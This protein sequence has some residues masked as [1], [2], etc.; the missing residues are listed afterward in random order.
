MTGVSSANGSYLRACP[1]ADLGDGE[2]TRVELDGRTDLP[3]PHRGRGARR[4]A[5]CART[6]TSRSSEGEV[7]GCTIECWLHGSRFD[8][9]TGEPTG[10]PGHRPGPRL[11]RQDRRTTTST[12]SLVTA[13]GG[14]DHGQPS[15]SATC[16]SSVDDRRGRPRDPAR[17]RPHGPRRARRTRSW[18]RTARA[19]RRWPTRSPGTRSTRSP[20]GSV[21]LDGADVLAMTR[22]RAGPGRPVPRHAVPG[23]GPRRLRLELPAHGGDRDRAARRRSCAPGSRRSTAR[24]SGWP[25]TR[26]SPS[27]TSTRASPA[28]RRSATRSCSW[29]CSSPKIAILDETDSGLDVDAL[30]VVSEGVNRVRDDRRG[31]RAADH[32]LHPDPALHQAGLRARL[33]RRPHRRG[34]WPR[35]GRPARGRGLRAV[36]DGGG[37]GDQRD[38][39]CTTR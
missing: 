39:P 35:A 7:D 1:L 19:S 13:R 18:G 17:R 37:G 36:R 27:A 38:Q 31:R 11:P 10:L 4:R 15:R 32:P 34:G 20:Q 5:T 6:P 28:A 8:L 3:G 12:S 30:R 14:A 9:R 16:T 25:S 33:R 24:W 23:R 21:T 22:R 29:S 2:A 26:P